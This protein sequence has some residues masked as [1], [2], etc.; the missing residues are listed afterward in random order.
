VNQKTAPRGSLAPAHSWPLW[1]SMMDRQIE[2]P[3][4]T[5]PGFVV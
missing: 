3:I 5:P 2:S 4:P 1:A